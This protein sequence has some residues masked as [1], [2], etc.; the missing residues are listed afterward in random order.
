MT[1]MDSHCSNYSF[2]AAIALNNIGVSLLERKSYIDALDTF[3]MSLKIFDSIQLPQL[4]SNITSETEISSNNVLSVS[5]I[6]T[7][8]NIK[9]ARSSIV[10][11]GSNDTGDLCYDEMELEVISVVGSAFIDNT[12]LLD[13]AIECPNGSMVVAI[14]LDNDIDIDS[15]P[16]TAG[17]FHLHSRLESAIVMYNIGTLYRLYSED[18]VFLKQRLSTCRKNQTRRNRNTHS[19]IKQIQKNLYQ[20][21]YKVLQQAKNITLRSIDTNNTNDSLDYYN[22]N[23]GNDNSVAPTSTTMTLQQGSLLVLLLQNLMFIS[24]DLGYERTSRVYYSQYCD[25]RCVI[26]Q[27]DTSID[28]Q[29]NNTSEEATSNICVVLTNQPT[30][31]AEA[32]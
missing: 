31:A 29:N 27:S 21:G 6:V 26:C 17:L 13:T 12:S 3:Q 32:A 7:N 10:G 5:D 24:S 15:A 1:S 25:I 9:L 19:D 22:S 20:K 14:R 18:T 16:M 30:T 2:N 23:S 11:Q 28:S 4:A 8:A